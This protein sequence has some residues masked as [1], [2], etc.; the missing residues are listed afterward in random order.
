MPR[1]VPAL[2]LSL[3]AISTVPD[4][5]DRLAVALDDAGVS[6]VHESGT[7]AAPVWRVFLSDPEQSGRVA[8]QL[9]E[10]FAAD[11]VHA[12]AVEIEDE[13]WAARTQAHLTHIVVGRLVVAPPWDVPSPLARETHLIVIPPSMGF[14]TGHHETTRLC[15]RLLQDLDLR[16]KRV[17]DVG[18][19]SGILAIAAWLLGAT[20]VEGL[21]HDEDALASARQSI[22][23]NG[24]TG[25]ILL[26]AGDIRTHRTAAADVVTANLTGA[27]LVAVAPALASLVDGGGSLILSGFQPHES[28]GVLQAFAPLARVESLILDGEWQAAHLVRRA[29]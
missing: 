18:T 22:A 10:Q 28:D 24:L 17:V 5:A 15:L 14:G 20:N 27:L 23:V 13:D 8:A 19:G 11:G 21:D 25:R 26:R 1:L 3:P 12:A 2:E 29:E 16:K 4:L 7:D 9:T 6:A